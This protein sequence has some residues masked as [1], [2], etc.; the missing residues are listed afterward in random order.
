MYKLGPL[1]Q[2]EMIQNVP[3]K[4][5]ERPSLTGSHLRPSIGMSISIFYIKTVFFIRLL[6]QN[7]D[8]KFQNYTIQK[9]RQAV[10]TWERHFVI[11][12]QHV[13]IK[14]ILHLKKIFVV[15]A[16]MDGEFYFI[17][18]SKKFLGH[19]YSCNLLRSFE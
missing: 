2:L 15:H 7:Y 18:L 17:Y 5:L 12:V 4:V 3:P 10:R 11:V 14:V 9:V 6:K 8:Y 13:E 16:T 1:D 19:N